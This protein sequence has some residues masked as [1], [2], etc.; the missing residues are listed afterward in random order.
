MYVWSPNSAEEKKWPCPR[1]T[2]I[3][4]MVVIQF[5]GHIDTALFTEY[6]YIY[7]PGIQHNKTLMHRQEGERNRGMGGGGG[8][9][10]RVPFS[11]SY[12]EELFRIGRQRNGE[13]FV[14]LEAVHDHLLRPCR[15]EQ[16]ERD[17]GGHLLPRHGEHRRAFQG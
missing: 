8:V 3:K 13:L 11:L 9:L 5:H 10:T 17:S 16:R 1:L 12:P 7:I 15:L 14:G 2:V 6:K 4:K